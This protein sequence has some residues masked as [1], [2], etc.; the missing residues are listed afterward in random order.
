[1]CSGH[2]IASHRGARRGGL[3]AWWER[4][5][6][7]Q[8]PEVLIEASANI[9][10]KAESAWVIAVRRPVSPRLGDCPSFYR[11]R[12]E[13]FT[14]VPHYSLAC[15]SM[16]RSATELTVILANHLPAGASWCVLCSY[17]SGFK[18]GGIGARTRHSGSHGDV[19]SPRTPT[20][21]GCRHSSRRGAA[22]AGMA[23]QD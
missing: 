14:C 9:V 15:G 13:Q 3:Q 1:M 11:P 2:C 20:A 21:S 5:P 10:E 4:R 12:R 16:A 8:V 6:G 17:R 18:G 19:L 23:A 7:L 22:V